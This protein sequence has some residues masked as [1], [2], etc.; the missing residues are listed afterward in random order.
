MN[1]HYKLDK[2]DNNHEEILF[3]KARD[4]EKGCVGIILLTKG[5][6]GGGG[7]RFF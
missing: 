6:G 2:N 5:R 7:I 1:I 4:Q 3:L